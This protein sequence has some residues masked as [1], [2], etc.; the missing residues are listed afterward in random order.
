M[1]TRKFDS[2]DYVNSLRRS[3]INGMIKLF[4]LQRAQHEPVYGGSLIKALR[5]FGYTMSPG[6][7]YPLLHTLEQTKLL[8][9]HTITVQGRVRRYYEITPF[10]RGCYTEARHSLAAFVQEMLFDQDMRDLRKALKEKQSSPST[11]S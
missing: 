8:K 9:S 4:I 6:T 10:G 2:R 11:S 5:K 3:L 7:L 1:A